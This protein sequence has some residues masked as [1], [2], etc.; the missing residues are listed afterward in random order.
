MTE[1]IELSINGRDYSV[2]AGISVA[3]ALRLAAPALPLRVS[4]RGRE[5]RGVFCGMGMCFDCLIVV[6][7]MKDVRS[8][9]TVVRP[10]MR[11]E[12]PPA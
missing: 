6:D 10:G 9:M 11:I 2:P 12:T 3:A 5:P 7:G 1:P 4:H 8:C